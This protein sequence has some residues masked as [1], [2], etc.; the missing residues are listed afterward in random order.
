MKKRE[1][2]V[3]SELRRDGLS[4]RLSPG[5]A[6]RDRRVRRTPRFPIRHNFK[7]WDYNKAAVRKVEDVFGTRSVQDWNPRAQLASGIRMPLLLRAGQLP[8]GRGWL[9]CVVELP[10]RRFDCRLPSPKKTDAGMATVAARSG[11]LSRT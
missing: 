3:E 1:D 6:F 9:R 7:E 5:F 10:K 8:P 4:N 11:S 2:R